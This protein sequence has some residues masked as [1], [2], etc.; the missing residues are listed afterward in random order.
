[1]LYVGL[2]ISGI[3]LVLY[4]THT[5]LYNH[6]LRKNRPDVLEQLDS[7]RGGSRMGQKGNKER[8][9]RIVITESGT[10]GWVILLGFPAMPI[11]LVGIVV[12]ILSLVIKALGWIF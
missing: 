4:I 3:G 1:M 2:A 11:F 7:K 5:I 12:T 6:Y 9:V 8:E 10:P